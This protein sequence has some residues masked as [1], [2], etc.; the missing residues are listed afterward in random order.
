MVQTTTFFLLLGVVSK[1]FR[2]CVPKKIK[3]KKKKK[4]PGENNVKPRVRYIFTPFSN[5]LIGRLFH[6]ST[7]T[8]RF[9]YFMDKYLRTI[10]NRA[11]EPIIFAISRFRAISIQDKRGIEKK[12]RKKKKEKNCK[13]SIFQRGIN[14]SR[15]HT[16]RRNY[17]WKKKKF[18]HRNFFFESKEEEKKREIERL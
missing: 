4:R 18:H 12:E 16:H 11:T 7:N 14:E 8:A 6:F 15:I 3:K 17:S 10:V 5:A 1:I 13:L 2:A 9:K